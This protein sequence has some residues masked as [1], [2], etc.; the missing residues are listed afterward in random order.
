[1]KG[2]LRIVFE[3]EYGMQEAGIDGGGLF[4]D[5]MENLIKQA[6]DPQLGLFI[7]T[8]DNR[9]YPN[10]NANLAVDSCAEA[11]QFLGK[12]VGK[13]LYE[14][15]RVIHLR[16]PPIAKENIF[17]SDRHQHDLVVCSSCG[18]D[19]LHQFSPC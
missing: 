4:K 6:F 19:L 3:D 7:P 11:F 18:G 9:L 14:V 15:G 13:A 10:P 12:M 17:F 5:F 1:M 16:D 8:S 2:R